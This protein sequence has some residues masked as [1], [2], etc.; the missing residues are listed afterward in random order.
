MAA[1]NKVVECPTNDGIIEHANI[2][3]NHTD[4]IANSL[5]MITLKISILMKIYLNNLITMQ[6]NKKKEN[7]SLNSDL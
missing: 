7:K 1:G 4:G 3:V 2:D 6:N 5:L